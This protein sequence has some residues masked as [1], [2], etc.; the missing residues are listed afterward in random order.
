MSKKNIKISKKKFTATKIDV[1][2]CRKSNVGTD[3]G[4]DVGTAV[5]AN[6]GSG[7]GDFGRISSES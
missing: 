3:V 4:P 1:G 2:N 6:V 7:V 5:G